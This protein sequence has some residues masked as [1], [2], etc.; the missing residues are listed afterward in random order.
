MQYLED[1]DDVEEDPLFKIEKVNPENENDNFLSLLNK[2]IEEVYKDIDDKKI[3][4]NVDKAKESLNKNYRIQIKELEDDNE[5]K[6]NV[7]IDE[8]EREKINNENNALNEDIS[9]NSIDNQIY[10]F[11]YHRKTVDDNGGKI[12]ENKLD[13]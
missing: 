7:V 4:L 9:P 3:G 1:L 11:E 10:H 13:V 8:N 12:N 6:D 2:P 5:E